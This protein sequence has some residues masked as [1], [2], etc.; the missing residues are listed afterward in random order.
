MDAGAGVEVTGPDGVVDPEDV[1]PV[2][3]A[4][5]TSRARIRRRMTLLLPMRPQLKR[6]AA[7]SHAV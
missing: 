6:T 4:A 5:A 7:N 2:T 3:V 1:Q